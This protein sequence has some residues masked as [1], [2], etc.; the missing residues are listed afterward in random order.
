MRATLVVARHARHLVA[1]DALGRGA[2]LDECGG[3]ALEDLGRLP[4][5]EFLE[6]RLGHEG[7]VD[8]RALE[9]PHMAVRVGRQHVNGH[10]G[11]EEVLALIALDLARELLREIGIHGIAPLITDFPPRP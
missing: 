4:E 6:A 1:Q 11:F 2:L 8:A 10:G 5:I 7:A 9:Q 3:I